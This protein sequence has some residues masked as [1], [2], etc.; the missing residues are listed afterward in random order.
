MYAIRV[1]FP[2]L[3]HRIFNSNFRG[4]ELEKKCEWVKG[5]KET[6]DI[7]HPLL[8]IKGGP[9][10]TKIGPNCSFLGSQSFWGLC[11]LIL[12]LLFLHL[13]FQST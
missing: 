7:I 2:N 10:D 8:D 13:P 4:T 6:K 11:H 3:F 1:E 5:T 9:A 12:A